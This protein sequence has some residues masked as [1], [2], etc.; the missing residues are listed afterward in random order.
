MAGMGENS[1]HISLDWRGAA[2][3]TLASG[4]HRGSDP[5]ASAT[6]VRRES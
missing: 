4:K 3:A 6:S 1:I 5:A 2:G